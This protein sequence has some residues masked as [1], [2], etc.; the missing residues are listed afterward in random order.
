VAQG[1]NWPLSL[2]LTFTGSDLFI[3]VKKKRTKTTLH[4]IGLAHKLSYPWPLC[5]HCDT[6]PLPRKQVWPGP[7]L[8]VWEAAPSLMDREMPAVHFPTM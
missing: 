8:L 3:L 4:C 1:V 6:P 5:C 2:T 7:P